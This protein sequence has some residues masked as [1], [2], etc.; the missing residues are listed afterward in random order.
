MVSFMIS[1]IKGHFNEKFGNVIE[2]GEQAATPP[3]LLLR[4]SRV[5]NG[6][7][8]YSVRVFVP[9]GHVCVVVE[10]HTV[11]RY[12]LNEHYK[13]R[14]TKPRDQRPK[15]EIHIDL[16]FGFQSLDFGLRALVLRLGYSG[17]GLLLFSS[18]F[19]CALVFRL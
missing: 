18:G 7:P 6:L 11:T 10:V 14:V 3:T 13:A 5:R 12:A 15:P 19:G 9:R 4:T 16:V 1:D 17:F 2:I 8:L